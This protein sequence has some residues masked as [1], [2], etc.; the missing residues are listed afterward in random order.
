MMRADMAAAYVDERSVQTFLNKVGT[1]YPR[2]AHG[3]GTTA[4][5]Q[6]SDLDRMVIGSQT[7]GEELAELI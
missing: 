3:A 1:H 6:K 4:A 5:W 7:G 2:S